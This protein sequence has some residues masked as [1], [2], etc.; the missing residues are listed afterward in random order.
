MTSIIV[1]FK[2]KTKIIWLFYA[3]MLTLQSIN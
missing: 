3:Q 2:T 1:N